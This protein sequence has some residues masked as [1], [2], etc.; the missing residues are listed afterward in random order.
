MRSGTTYNGAL[1]L[2]DYQTNIGGIYIRSWTGSGVTEDLANKFT[3]K[4]TNP[5]SGGNA[6][7]CG[8][9]CLG[10]IWDVRNIQ[11]SC[12]VSEFTNDHYRMQGILVKE[13]TLNLRGF[14][15]KHVLPAA[16]NNLTGVSRAL[17][18]RGVILSGNGKIG[19]SPGSSDTIIELV[20][21]TTITKSYNMRPINAYTG[22]MTLAGSS[23]AEL[24]HGYIDLKIPKMY[25]CATS[26][27]K[28]QLVVSSLFG[29]VVDV[30]RVRMATGF[31]ATGRRYDCSSGGSIFVAN[32]GAEFFPG[33]EAGY[34]DAATYSWYK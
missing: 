29:S 7:E 23:T 15:V 5:A 27:S 8:M 32:Q 25:I 16:L 31:T 19:I 17:D 24:N 21:Q 3:I 33:A 9:V 22:E 6:G 30:L 12:E 13:G 14:H 18:Y 4:R 28:G 20:E 26:S 1:I 2:P 34:V 11:V 10:G